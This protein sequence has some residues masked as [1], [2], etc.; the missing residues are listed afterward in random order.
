MELVGLTSES[1]NCPSVLR[2]THLFVLVSLTFRFIV[3]VFNRPH[4][5]TKITVLILVAVY[6]LE[7][8]MCGA[9]DEN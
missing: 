2:F 4:L 6:K 5:N 7:T 8:R 3:L 1:L 9:K